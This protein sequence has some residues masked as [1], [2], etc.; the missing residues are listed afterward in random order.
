MKFFGKLHAEME[1]IQPQMVEV[2]KHQRA[3]A[4]K[5]VKHHCTEFELTAVMIAGSLA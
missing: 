2:K 3:N 4:L 1:A 5:E